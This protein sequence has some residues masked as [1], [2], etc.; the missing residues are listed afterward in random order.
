MEMA[1]GFL[2]NGLITTQVLD[3]E[4]KKI[5]NTIK[6]E[7][8]ALDKDSLQMLFYTDS[9]SD[10]DIKQL[11][12]NFFKF[13]PLKNG[14]TIGLTAEL[15]SQ[16]S[17]AQNEKIISEVYE[18]WVT[19]NNLSTIEE[20][21]SITLYLKDLRMSDRQT[22]FDEFWFL[23]KN[24]LGTIELKFI[25][26]DLA[27]QKSDTENSKPKLTFNYMEGKNTPTFAL[28]TDIEERI[29]NEFNPKN[30]DPLT[31]IE[32]DPQS[33]YNTI[34]IQIDGSPILV[35]SSQ[36]HL[37]SLQKALLSGLVAGLQTENR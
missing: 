24:T 32:F 5:I 18:K 17:F 4:N 8:N 31:F 33:K 37:N 19:L 7:I 12:Q 29:F 34:F 13:F 11:Y 14:K 22:F 36:F 2:D 20:L 30:G 9:T 21:V 35:L 16:N 28:G 3:L 10:E 1:V 23:L 15:F 27:F 25:F 26:H 6:T